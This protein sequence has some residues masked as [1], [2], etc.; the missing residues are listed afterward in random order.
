MDTYENADVTAVTSRIQ[1]G[2][3][4]LY[5]DPLK[6]LESLLA[7]LGPRPPVSQPAYRALA[8]WA[9][10]LINPLPV[11]GVSLEI[12]GRMLEAPNI[13]RRLEVLEHGLVRICN[14]PFDFY[15]SVVMRYKSS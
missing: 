6:L 9:A 13:K 12:R 10:G 3:P 8:F 14:I 1:S 11:L 5:V 15:N 2:R 4:G 7:D